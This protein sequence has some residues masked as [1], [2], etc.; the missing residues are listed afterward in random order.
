MLRCD[1]ITLFPGM[2]TTVAQESILGRAV[3]KGLLEVR[4]HNLRD[5]AAGRH[6]VAD[7]HPYGGGAG[8]VLKAEPFF[9]AVEAIRAQHLEHDAI[10]L[11]LMTPQGRPFTQAMARE[12]SEE[13]RRLVFLCGHYEGIDE[14]VRT[15]LQPEA[16]SIGDY[17]LT[18]GELAALVVIDAAARCIPGVLGDPACLE[19]ESFAGPGGLL[20]HPHYTRPAEVRGLRVPEVLLTGDHEAILEWRRAEATTNTRRARP[21]LM[22]EDAP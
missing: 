7:D 14:R 18:G 1:V 8:M 20:E 17:V 3:A 12:L 10:R 19:E 6:R 4:A 2:V 11:L 21:D 9:A 13:S 15:G 16:L 22:T 5:Y